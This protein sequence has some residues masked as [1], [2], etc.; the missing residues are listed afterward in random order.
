[1]F[2]HAIGPARVEGAD[3]DR[4]HVGVSVEAPVA[5][6]GEAPQRVGGCDRRHATAGVAD[7]ARGGAI[8]RACLAG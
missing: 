8:R 6:G 5:A 2:S 3:T 1:M 4:V 7:V